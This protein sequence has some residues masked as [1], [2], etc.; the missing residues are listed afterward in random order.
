MLDGH[1][2]HI[3]FRF[4]RTNDQTVVVRDAVKTL[5]QDRR[6]AKDDTLFHAWSTSLS[7]GQK[8]KNL[9]MRAH[10]ITHDSADLNFFFHPSHQLQMN[11]DMPQHLSNRQPSAC[12]ARVV[13]T[14]AQMTKH[15]MPSELESSSACDNNT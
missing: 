14:G 6:R 15:T 13:L 11:G 1:H 2:T 7:F 12:V 3:H 4:R 5:Q 10:C 9:R 8:V